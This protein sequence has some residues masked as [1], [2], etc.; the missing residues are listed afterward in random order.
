MIGMMGA[1]FFL[2]EVM[3]FIVFFIFG[4]IIVK[5]ILGWN[6]N[7]HAP[8]ITVEAR[9][10]DKRSHSSRHHHGTRMHTS[11]TSTSYYVTFEVQ[12]RD[13]MELCVPAQEFGLLIVGD[14]GELTFQGTRYL[15]FQR[16]S[17]QH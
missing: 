8:R 15:S 17:G 11:H 12:G 2:F 1:S 3:F 7:N 6:K 14:E 9:V 16:R 10:L 13:R 5:G 4:V